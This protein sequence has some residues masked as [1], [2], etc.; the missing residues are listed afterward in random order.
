MLILRDERG[1]APAEFAMVVGLLTILTLSVLQLGLALHIRN[2]VLEDPNT[3]PP[4]LDGTPVA[5]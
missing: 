5:D 3:S 4:D 1:S 2:T